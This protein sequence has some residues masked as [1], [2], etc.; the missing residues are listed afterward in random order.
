[1]K[2]LFDRQHKLENKVV[3]LEKEMMSLVYA[4]IKGLEHLQD[5]LVR[6]GKH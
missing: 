5:E 2:K 1:M 4:S 3:K 6:E